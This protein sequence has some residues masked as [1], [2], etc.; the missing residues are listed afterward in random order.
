MRNDGACVVPSHGT[1]SQ[2]V[3]QKGVSGKSGVRCPIAMER[4]SGFWW[5]A[6]GDDDDRERWARLS[7]AQMWARH[8]SAKGF[9]SMS[10]SRSAIRG[11]SGA[12]ISSEIC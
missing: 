3:P 4:G 9:E 8:D 12:L 11:R 5:P 7:R 2:C 1:G 10:R 6:F